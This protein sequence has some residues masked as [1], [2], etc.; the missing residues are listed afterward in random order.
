MHLHVLEPLFKM[1]N[2]FV[3]K[4]VSSCRL[5][6]PGKNCRQIYGKSKRLKKF[7]HSNGPEGVSLVYNSYFF[8]T[9][10]LQKLFDIRF[11]YVQ[12]LQF[13]PLLAIQKGSH[14]VTA[15]GSR[16]KP[17]H[18]HKEIS[19]KHFSCVYSFIKLYFFP[20][21]RLSGPK[22][23]IRGYHSSTFLAFIAHLCLSCRKLIL[24]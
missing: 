8:K 23:G 14:C 4:N 22:T 1:F 18:T 15:K 12:T 3:C 10:V 21:C 5:K 11:S 24:N 13:L 6:F 2:I 9:A 20:D 17:S 7:R 16:G 19:K